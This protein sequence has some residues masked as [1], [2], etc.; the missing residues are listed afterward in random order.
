VED[1]TYSWS[2]NTVDDYGLLGDIAGFDE[3]D[4]LTGIN[5]YTWGGLNIEQ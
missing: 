1:I 3:H 5:T 2:R 4:E